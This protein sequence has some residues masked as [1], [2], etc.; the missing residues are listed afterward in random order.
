MMTFAEALMRLA[1]Q[2]GK[3]CT[4]VDQKRNFFLTAEFQWLSFT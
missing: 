2:R 3:M 4:N 1:K